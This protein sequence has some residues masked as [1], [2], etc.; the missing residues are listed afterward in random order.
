LF[1]FFR[2]RFELLSR[3]IVARR[4]MSEPESPDPLAQ[5]VSSTIAVN[6]ADPVPVEPAQAMPP[7]TRFLQWILFGGE[8]LRVGWSAVLFVVLSQIFMAFFGI[9]AGLIVNAN[10]SI[11]SKSSQLSPAFTILTETVS[12]LAVLAAA[13]IAAGIEHRRIVGYYLSGPRRLLHFLSG[14]FGGF[15]A[16][17][18]LAAA[19]YAAG[20]LHVGRATL[21]PAQTLEFGAMWTIAFLFTACF[22]EGGFRCYLLYTLARGI[23][24]WWA[25]GSAASLCALA[26][27]NRHGSDWGGVCLMALVGLLPCLL[28]QLRQAP[29]AGF[30]QA[31][32]LTSTAFGYIHTFN[33][34][35]NWIGIFSASALG[36]IFC[37]SIRLTGSAWWAIGFHGAWDWA[38][39]FFYGTADSGL[40]PKGHYLTTAPAGP[41]LWSG[42][43]NG[44]EGSVLVLPIILL[45]LVGLVLIYRRKS[46]RESP[47][48]AVQPQ[49]S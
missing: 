27:L 1:A 25:L 7:E 35:E 10:R 22:E 4:F 23:N 33:P 24:F 28:L 18:I 38:Q 11:D 43:S 21:T 32:W 37:V 6:P 29:S 30:W 45:V 31:A 42:G 2:H 44:P 47:S 48:P 19:L 49:L 20:F 8:G 39:T 15:A 3:K 14:A 26:L 36:F 41:E 13:A 34:D 12:V 40:A 5:P 9:G 16:L 46:V 17:S